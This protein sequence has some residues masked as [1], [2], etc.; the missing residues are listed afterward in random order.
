[1]LGFLKSQ[2]TRTTLFSL[3][4]MEM[5]RLRETVVFPSPGRV[6]VITRIFS[7]SPMR[8]IKRVRRARIDS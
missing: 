5:A 4:A 7:F 1:M 3:W 8:R 2:S 6:L